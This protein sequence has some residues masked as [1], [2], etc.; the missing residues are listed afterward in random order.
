M[1]FLLTFNSR[2]H[3]EVDYT[4][5]SFFSFRQTF[6]SRPHAEVDSISFKRRI[7]GSLSTHDLTQRSTSGTENA[8][9]QESTFNSRPHAEVDLQPAPLSVPLCTFN[10]RPHAEVDFLRRRNAGE[11]KAFNSRPHAEVDVA[12]LSFV[13]SPALFQLTTSRRGRPVCL[14][15]SCKPAHLSTHDLTQRSTL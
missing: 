4:V 13:C 5:S 15:P 12:P 7:T 2:P 1:T 10:S 9:R 11:R 14:N 8:E 3:A 6:N